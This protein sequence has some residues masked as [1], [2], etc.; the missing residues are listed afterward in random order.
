MVPVARLRLSRCVVKYLGS[1][2][3]ADWF[4]VDVGDVLKK[5]IAVSEPLAARIQDEIRSGAL[6][7]GAHLT[8]QGLADRFAVQSLFPALGGVYFDGVSPRL[9]DRAPPAAFCWAAKPS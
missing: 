5:K 4:E 1:H 9:A 8:A 7:P 2:S 3:D 6:G